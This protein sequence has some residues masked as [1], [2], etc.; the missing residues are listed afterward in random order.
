MKYKP[1]QRSGTEVL[2]FKSGE[3]TTTAA[4]HIRDGLTRE[5]IRQDTP[6]GKWYEVGSG[7]YVDP[8]TLMCI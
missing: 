4:I 2:S 7:Q 3:L 6:N 5:K 1:Q 8:I